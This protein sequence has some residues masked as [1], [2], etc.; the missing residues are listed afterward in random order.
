MASLF[1][2]IAALATLNAIRLV[3]GKTI[4]ERTGRFVSGARRAVR[5]AK[6]GVTCIF[7]SF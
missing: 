1:L 4:Q 7:V 6:P 3:Y 5:K 2:S